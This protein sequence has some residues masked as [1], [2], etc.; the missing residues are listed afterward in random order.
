MRGRGVT[1]SGRESAERV[2]GSFRHALLF[3]FFARCELFFRGTCIL[4]RCDVLGF[5]TVAC[6]FDCVNQICT[7]NILHGGSRARARAM[8]CGGGGE[9]KF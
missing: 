8:I 6:E 7:S 5:G 2:C 3:F 1:A 9:R 4:Y